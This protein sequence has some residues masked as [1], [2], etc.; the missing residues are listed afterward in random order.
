MWYLIKFIL[1]RNLRQSISYLCSLTFIALVIITYSYNKA[2]ALDRTSQYYIMWIKHSYIIHK[3]TTH[4]HSTNYN[5]H[6]G[7]KKMYDHKCV[8]TRDDRTSHETAM[9]L[10]SPVLLHEFVIARFGHTSTLTKHTPYC[11]HSCPCV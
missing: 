10:K 9:K 5:H 8:V 7:W 3:Q 2:T 11:M 6:D 1:Y 4:T